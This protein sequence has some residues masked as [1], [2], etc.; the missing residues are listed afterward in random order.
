[1]RAIHFVLAIIAAAPVAAWSQGTEA[2]PEGKAITLW[3]SFKYGMSPEEVVTTLQSVEG[4]KRAK[5]KQNRK[6][7]KSVDID[8][9]KGAVSIFGLSNTLGLAIGPQGLSYLT[10]NSEA[11]LFEARE[12]Y[13]KLTELLGEKYGAGKT[14]KRL[15]PGGQPVGIDNHFSD[16]QTH[17]TLALDI[18][19][20][21]VAAPAPPGSG[22]I[23]A[24]AEALLQSA[25]DNAIEACPSE[26]GFKGLITIRYEA[27]A[28]V[29]A[30]DER[31]QKLEEAERKAALSKL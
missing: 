6:G 14:V 19:H 21:P 16:G 8:Y 7:A 12:K 1:M 24:L 29:A 17:V 5:L 11:C 3:G 10:L 26:Q 9:H 15:E 31:Q 13:D 30:R 2:A 20:P 18:D 4:V 22:Q 25:Q 28:D 27:A 23:G